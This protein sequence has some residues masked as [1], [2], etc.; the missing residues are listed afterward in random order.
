MADSSSS[1]DTG[2]ELPPGIAVPSELIARPTCHVLVDRV[3]Q[4]HLQPSIISVST[5]WQFHTQQSNQSSAGLAHAVATRLSRC[6]PESDTQS[7]LG[8]RTGLAWICLAWANG[9][10]AQGTNCS[11]LHRLPMVS[12]LASTMHRQARLRHQTES[13]CCSPRKNSI[14]SGE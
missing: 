12:P 13:F 2:D 6:W 9:A 1:D 10:C 11:G 4:D 14:C 8:E 7:T 5:P 3:S